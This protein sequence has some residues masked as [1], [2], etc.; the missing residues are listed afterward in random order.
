MLRVSDLRAGYAGIEVLKGVSLEVGPGEIVALIGA[1][2]AGKTTLLRTISGLIKASDGRVE[3]DGADATS[4]PTEALARAGLVHVPEGRNVFPRMTVRENLLVATWRRGSGVS[5]DLDRTSKL[6]PILD[7]R[8]NQQAYTL[9]GGEQQML[10]LGRAIMRD[11]RLLMLD[12]P[13]MGLAP[14]V[15]SEVFDLIG[16]LHQGGTPVLLVEQNAKSALRLAS[17]AYVLVN[18]SIAA[19]GSADELLSSDMIKRAYLGEN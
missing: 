13:S 11:P 17:R 10:A 4:R 16:K 14:L 2:G 6:F 8:R 9:S 3:F 7:Q 15:A 12:E 18:G 19:E 1:N 5:E